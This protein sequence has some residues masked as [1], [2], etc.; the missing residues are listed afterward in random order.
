MSFGQRTTAPD[1][2]IPQGDTA[3]SRTR[4]G[5]YPLGLLA[6]VAAA[7]LGAVVMSLVPAMN[8]TGVSILA[9]LGVAT[10]AIVSLTVVAAIPMLLIDLV[11]RTLNWRRPWI[12]ALACGV[13]LY[14]LCLGLEFS[15]GRFNPHFMA[16][17]VLWPGAAGGWVMGLFRR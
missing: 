10:M 7:Y 8:S 14:A 6:F 13:I 1:G 12:Y 15:N 9:I 3:R 5:G 17:M 16:G 4:R 11:L 2:E